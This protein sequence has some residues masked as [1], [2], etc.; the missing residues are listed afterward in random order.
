MILGREIELIVSKEGADIKFYD[1]S[2]ISLSNWI[3]FDIEFTFWIF[4]IN[5]S[6]SLNF[7]WEKE[8]EFW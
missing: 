1:W 2:L 5:F 6:P 8:I 4:T 7:F 3:A